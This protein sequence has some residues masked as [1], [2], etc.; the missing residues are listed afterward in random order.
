MNRFI[1]S[2]CALLLGLALAQAAEAAPYRHGYAKLKPAERAT[3]ARSQ[4]RLDVIKFR[5]WAD[6]HVTL[7]ERAKIRVA[8][9]RHKALVYRLRHN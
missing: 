3:L 2:T 8:E 4:H 1:F 6:G 9:Q 5:A 7:W